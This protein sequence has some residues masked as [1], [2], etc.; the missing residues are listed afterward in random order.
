MKCARLIFY[1]PTLS[2]LAQSVLNLEWG[3]HLLR[4]SSRSLG[5]ISRKNITDAEVKENHPPPKLRQSWDHG[6]AANIPVFLL[7]QRGG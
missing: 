3:G 2:N 7:S 6:E 5:I 4:S 1:L